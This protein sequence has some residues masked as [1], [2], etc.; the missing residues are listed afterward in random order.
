MHST[1][2]DATPMPKAVNPRDRF[3]GKL[4]CKCLEHIRQGF[5]KDDV[6]CV[7]GGDFSMTFKAVD[8]AFQRGLNDKE[9]GS[10]GWEVSDTD[11]PDRAFLFKTL[12]EGFYST[13]IALLMNF[14][15]VHALVGA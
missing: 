8:A 10:R 9:H 11:P 5:D 15:G 12:P 13:N 2:D 6:T 14:E 7:L 3:K 4:V 1:I